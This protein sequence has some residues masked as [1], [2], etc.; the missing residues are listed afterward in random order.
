MKSKINTFSESNIMKKN[1]LYLATTLILL[2]TLNCGKPPVGIEFLFESHLPQITCSNV[3]I[4]FESLQGVSIPL[5]LADTTGGPFNNKTICRWGNF[6]MKDYGEIKTL[7]NLLIENQ[8]DTLKLILD[9][10]QIQSASI[11]VYEI[12]I[13]CDSSSKYNNT[14]ERVPLNTFT[15]TN[16][17]A[18][19]LR[20]SIDTRYH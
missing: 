5:G 11:Y 9:T 20:S 1:V 10:V 15:S 16:D 14:W 4:S 17:T 19:I 18:Y 7:V 3:Y 2:T 6:D 12:N 13:A 8:N